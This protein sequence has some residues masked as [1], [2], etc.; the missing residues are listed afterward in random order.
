MFSFM[1]AVLTLRGLGTGGR[2]KA[3][4][5][6][7]SLVCVMKSSATKLNR[8]SFDDS[9][10]AN[11]VVSK[12]MVL[13]AHSRYVLGRREKLAAQLSQDQIPEFIQF[14]KDLE[15]IGSHGD[16]ASGSVM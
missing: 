1:Q 15:K 3:T 14:C 7:E 11:A 9:K 6:E 8:T 5:L 4:Q 13:M 16:S 12:L 2:F 10:F